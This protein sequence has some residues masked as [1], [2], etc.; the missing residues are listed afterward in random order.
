M[1]TLKLA[2][3][4]DPITKGEDAPNNMKFYGELSEKARLEWDPL[5]F[6]AF[7]KIMRTSNRAIATAIREYYAKTFHDICGVNLMYTPGPQAPFVFEF[8]FAKNANPK[9]DDK[10]ENLSDLTVATGDKTN[11][12]YQKQIVDNK[13]AGKHYTLNEQTKLLLSD[14][15]FGG[16]D[17][18]KPNNGRW[19]QYISEVWVPNSDWTFNPGA[20]KLLIKVAGCFD[21]HRVLQKLFGNSMVTKTL[22]YADDGGIKAKNYSS[23]PAYEARFIKYAFNE[24]NVFIMNIEQFDKSAVEEMTT[25]ENPIRR[26]TASGVIYY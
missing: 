26:S 14:I 1:A 19:N 4:V 10:I 12:F 8:Y 21:I 20:G 9:P 16:R 11:L 13:A 23:D 24:S 2:N 3:L 15:M 6:E 18:N 22:N 17:A 25:K 7:G 5:P